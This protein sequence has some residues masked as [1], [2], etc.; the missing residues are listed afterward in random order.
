MSLLKS[1][2]T[3][4]AEYEGMELRQLQTDRPEAVLSS[5]AVAPAGNGKISAD[6]LGSRRYQNSY[7]FYAK[8]AAGAEVD[9]QDNHDFL[10][11]LS[12]WMEERNEESD[13][14]TLPAGCEV[15]EISVSNGMLMDLYDDGTGLYQVQIQMIFTKRSLM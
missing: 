3:W 11:A 8:E 1:L 12:V 5:Y 15:E 6:I 2:Q 10:E 7:V 13:F 9:R 4:L 14:P